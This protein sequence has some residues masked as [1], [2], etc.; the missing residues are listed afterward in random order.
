MRLLSLA[1]HDFRNIERAELD[2]DAQF[3]VFQGENAQGKTNCLEAICCLATLK[4]FRTHRNRDLIRFGAE[5]ALVKGVVRD[6]DLQREFKFLATQK[7]RHGEVDGHRP[8]RLQRYFEG[9][10]AVQFAPEDATEAQ[11]NRM[12]MTT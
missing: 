7:G 4:S 11:S 3:V 1:V 5:R 12:G 2:T 10:R 8:E 6:L 9:I